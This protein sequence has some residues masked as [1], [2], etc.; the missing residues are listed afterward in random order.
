MKC[1]RSNTSYPPSNSTGVQDKF[2]SICGEVVPRDE[3]VF[4]TQT[5]IL[6]VVIVVCL[7]N[8]SIGSE[9]QS[10]F[11]G[12]LSSSLGY[13]LPNPSLGGK[14]M[15]KDILGCRN[16]PKTEEECSEVLSCDNVIEESSNIS[17]IDNGSTN[18][19]TTV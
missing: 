16:Q 18:N 3:V 12:L 5:I 13:M 15:Y 1:F 9:N 6:Y 11:I 7:V 14:R 17:N 10:V 8:L 4:F 2:W 19:K